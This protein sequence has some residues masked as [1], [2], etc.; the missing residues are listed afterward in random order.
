MD[1]SCR[2]TV[3]GCFKITCLFAT[4]IAIGYWCYKFSLDED[5]CLIDYKTY[6]EEAEDSFPVMSLCFPLNKQLAN[7]SE[8][9]INSATINFFLKQKTMNLTKEKEVF[10]NLKID[11]NF[12]YISII[13]IK[14]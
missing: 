8:I 13:R 11:L 2:K 6:Y 5:I 10:K 14:S 9:A 1:L 7:Y 3:H 12:Q 4:F